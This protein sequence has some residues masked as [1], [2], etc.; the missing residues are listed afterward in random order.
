MRILIVW[1]VGLNIVDLLLTLHGIQTEALA[2]ANPIMAHALESG[3]WA[4]A[5]VK[6]TLVIGGSVVLWTNKEKRMAI[7]GAHTGVIIYITVVI[8]HL[9]GFMG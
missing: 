3:P 6:M 1:L 2:E 9:L 5:C 7:L 8:V 4:M